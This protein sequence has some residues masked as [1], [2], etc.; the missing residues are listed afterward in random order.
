MKLDE[1][2]DDKSD[3]KEFSNNNFVFLIWDPSTKINYCRGF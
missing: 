3:L 2:V 1:F